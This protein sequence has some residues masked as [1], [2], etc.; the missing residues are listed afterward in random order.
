[1]VELDRT[2][3]GRAEIR[4]APVDLND[5]IQREVGAARAWPEQVPIEVDLD[6]TMT[7]VPGDESKLSEV[8]QTLLANAVMRSPAGGVVTVTTVN[9]ALG[10]SVTVRDQGVGVRAEFDDSLIDHDDL[11]A[12]SPIRKLVGTGLGLGIARQVV[13]MH[14][15]RLWVVR[16][17]EAGSEF[18]F[19]LPV[20]W[21]DRLA[22][23]A[24]SSIAGTVAS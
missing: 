15:G 1:M 8:M 24:P 4:I 14:G 21:R 2:E 23:G 5:L 16:T 20:S 10:V 13:Q 6:P 9:G 17:P 7:T 3:S 11:Y 22:A 18:H 19:T 12:N